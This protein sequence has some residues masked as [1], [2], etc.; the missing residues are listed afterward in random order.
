MAKGNT[1]VESSSVATSGIA[2]STR[3]C[4]AR[5]QL[6][7]TGRVKGRSPLVGRAPGVGRI[8]PGGDCGDDSAWF[9]GVGGSVDADL[10]AAIHFY[11]RLFDWHY[12]EHE[13]EMGTYVTARVEGGD[14][15]GM[16]GQAPEQAGMPPG[17]DGLRRLRPPREHARPGPGA[18]RLGDRDAALDPGWCPHR[19]D[20]GSHRRG[21]RARRRGAGGTHDRTGRARSP[22]WVE[23]QSR[24]VAESRDFYEGLFGWKAEEGTRGY[25]VFTRN[26]E[27]ICGLMAMPDEVPAEVP[28]HWLVYFV[29]DVAR[30]V[31][32]TPALGGT[33][34]HPT[35]DIDEGRFAV[36]ADPAGAVFA[37]FEEISSG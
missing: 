35:H 18:G 34:E 23:C 24:D 8:G 2:D 25:L 10:D 36:L 20:C 4:N 9:G 15:C 31:E 27:Q 28:S 3:S 12:E 6:S 13:T 17:L 11:E 5:F 37:V 19:G 22:G 21:A 16:M 14:V 7:P 30:A 33:V 1:S 29:A 32:Q 26:D